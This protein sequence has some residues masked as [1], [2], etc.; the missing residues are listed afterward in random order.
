V[1]RQVGHHH[2][3]VLLLGCHCSQSCPQR[4]Y[5]WNGGK[6]IMEHAVCVIPRLVAHLAESVLGGLPWAI[7]FSIL[8]GRFRVGLYFP[9]VCCT[10]VD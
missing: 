4:A 7:S 10:E 6:V 3:E 5:C 2:R 1:L 9:V 8:W